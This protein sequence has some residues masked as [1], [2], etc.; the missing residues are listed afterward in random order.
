M[1]TQYRCDNARR[2]QRLADP[3][4]PV[5]GIDYLEVLDARAAAVPT[6]RQRTLL[7]RCF[8]PVAALSEA[9]VRISGGV[10]IQS[11]QVGWARP[12][13][14]VPA[15][16][17]TEAE[18][19]FFQSLPDAA[20]V[21]VVRTD[22]PGD[23]S[24]YRLS[25][26]ASGFDPKSREVDF[27]FKVESPSEFDCRVDG[28]P[29]AAPAPALHID[30]LAKDYASFRQLML[31]RLAVVT[32]DWTERN[33]ADLGM[34][35]VEV[36]AY[37]A[38]RLSYYQDAV[39]TEAYL[40]TARRRVSVRRHARLLD[41]VVHEGCNARAWVRLT[42]EE[43]VDGRTLPAGAVLLTRVDAP[44]G[45]LAYEKLEESLHAGAQVFETMAPLKLHAVHN[46]LR[47]HAW[48]G[49]RCLLLTGATEA[50]FVDPAARLKLEAG[51][52]LVLGQ[53]R[54]PRTGLAVDADPTLRHAVRLTHVEATRDEL[55]GVDVV[56]VRWADEDA[57]PF[58]LEL[59]EDDA[60][61]AVAWG[62]VVLVDHGYTP[63][64]G[65]V[66]PALPST[67]RYRPVL[68]WGPVTRQGQVKDAD[69][70]L[71]P[72]DAGASATAALRWAV[73]DA[74]PVI[75]LEDEEAPERRWLAVSDLL[76]SDR[77]S[78][79]FVVESEEDGSA[80]LRFGDGIMGRKPQGGLLARYR[81]GNGRMG[82]VG[83]ETLA[84]VVLHPTDG[85]LNATLQGILDVSNP[86]PA[87]GGVD[88]ESLEHVRQN[89]PYAFRRH[90]RAVTAEDFAAAAE[91][92]PEVQKAVATRRWTGSWPTLYVTVDRYGG[93]PVDDAFREELRD[94]LERF[95]L[96]GHDLEIAAPIFAPLDIG[97]TVG[98]APGHFRGDVKAALL[99]VFS[100]GELPGGRRGFF[101]PDHFT[102]GQSV[103][104]SQLV[105]AAMR[106]PGVAWVDT[107]ERAPLRRFQRFGQA[108]N[109]E[110][111]TGGI[112]VKSL[113]IIR[114]DNDPSQPENGKLEF[115]L[116]GGL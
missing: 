35:L 21:L 98:V 92:H 37:A 1:G 34:A 56:N 42:V 19:T 32:P 86:L 88:P 114:L 97:L 26:S 4:A 105:H 107:S 7:V 30:Y 85:T 81:V 23:F 61:A 25:L 65:Q 79:H 94:F 87:V 40:A 60:P 16:R 17:T 41:Y 78:P 115:H 84:H 96:A 55:L 70:Q 10:R 112:R 11:I 82:N 100:S 51:D 111:E 93:R 9:N 53:V 75:F 5:N 2:R 113:E 3:A 43:G 80:F 103:Y 28:A 6:A 72:F 49:D 95:R 104:L 74:R 22:S 33:P 89:A 58:D 99:E 101:H 36:L 63:P 90:E 54:G 71:V 48:G 45:P 76:E 109:R 8:K 14:A 13:P 52:V 27:S 46:E 12:A 77:F 62:N 102:F 44:R 57:L 47:F 59:G 66:L 50:T 39:A 69:R 31:D 15:D 64:S 68:E 24:R 20:N 18:R 110:L 106:V 108:S 67:G 29:A 83:A 38:D 73:E 91:R 116:E